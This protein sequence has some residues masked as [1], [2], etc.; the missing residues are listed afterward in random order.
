MQIDKMG[1][2]V[3]GEQIKK[4][5]NDRQAIDK[6]II[7]LKA[8]FKKEV[9]RARATLFQPSNFKLVS[10]SRLDVHNFVV[11]HTRTGSIQLKVAQFW[12]CWEQSTDAGEFIRQWWGPCVRQTQAF[13][14]FIKV[15]FIMYK[16]HKWHVEEFTPPPPWYR[17][18]KPVAFEVI[19]MGEYVAKGHT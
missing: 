6:R 17:P 3:A 7:D 8:H 19:D 15:Q 11:R 10:A 13:P 1:I 14:E 5:L 4:A 18:F 16:V 9:K 12:G 2:D